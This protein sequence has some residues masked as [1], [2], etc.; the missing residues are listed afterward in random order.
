MTA[1]FQADTHRTGG[2][3]WNPFLALVISN[4]PLCIAMQLIWA[5][6][7]HAANEHWV[8]RRRAKCMGKGRR[9]GVQVIVVA[10]ALILMWM[11][12][13]EHAHARWGTDRRDAVAVVQRD[14]PGSQAVQ[15]WRAHHWV[16]VATGHKGAVLVG[17]DVPAP[18]NQSRLVR[19]PQD[20]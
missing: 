13:C 12:T 19:W 1:N 3:T 5:V 11:A 9:A 20:D 4:E 18:N 14:A 8:I 2:T 7:M 15:M 17:D 16:P 6:G 10:P